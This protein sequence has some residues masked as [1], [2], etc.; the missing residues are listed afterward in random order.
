MAKEKVK[1][2]K[3][4][5]VKKE[6]KNKEGFF[7]NLKKEISM[8]KWPSG[9]DLIK[10]TIATIFLCIILIAFFEILEFILANVTKIKGIIG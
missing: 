10:Y 2:V 9:K 7:K 3:K 5:K 8:V 4:K 1:D 6:K